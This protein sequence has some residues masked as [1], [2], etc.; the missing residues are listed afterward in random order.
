MQGDDDGGDDGD[1]DVVAL[2]V[3]V[4]RAGVERRRTR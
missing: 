4:T 1:G 2:A 3:T